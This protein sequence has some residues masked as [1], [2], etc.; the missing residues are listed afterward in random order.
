M[1][2]FV[3]NKDLMLFWIDSFIYTI[4]IKISESLMLGKD[5]ALN[6]A[7]FFSACLK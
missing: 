2:I 6:S 4:K 7:I 1:K 5:T 3:R